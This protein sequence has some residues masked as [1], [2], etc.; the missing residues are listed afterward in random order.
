MTAG[1]HFLCLAKRDW[2]IV[3]IISAFLLSFYEQ[4]KR[5]ND[6]GGISFFLPSQTTTVIKNARQQTFGGGVTKWLDCRDWLATRPFFFSL[7]PAD[8]LSGTKMTDIF[9][10]KKAVG[11][12]DI[13]HFWRFHW[14][15][16]KYSWNWPFPSPWLRQTKDLTD[17]IYLD[18]TMTLRL[19]DTNDWLLTWT[20]RNDWL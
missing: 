15:L 1:S 12:L 7:L 14:Y 11:S 8:G 13:R 19:D 17:T 16:T 5:L 4:N 3:C 2:L 10:F 6:C 18:W 9:L 20:W